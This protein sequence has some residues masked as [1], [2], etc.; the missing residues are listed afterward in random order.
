MLVDFSSTPFVR[1]PRVSTL[2]RCLALLLSAQFIAPLY[3]AGLELPKTL[4]KDNRSTTKLLVPSLQATTGK[5]GKALADEFINTH[6][7]E[8]SLSPDISPLELYSTRESLLGTHYRYRQMLNGIPVQGAEVVVSVR[9]KNDQVY[10]A[11]NNSYPIVHLPPQGKNLLGKEQALDTAW[12]HLQVHGRLFKKPEAQLVYLPGGENFRLVYQTDIACEAPLGNWRHLIDA[13]SGE[14]VSVKDRIIYKNSRKPITDDLAYKGAIHSRSDATAQLPQKA[15][16]K[17]KSSPIGKTTVN[18]T[19]L[20][21]DPDPRTHLANDALLDT[22]PASEFSAA[23][24]TRTLR[25]ISEDDGIYSLD[26]PWVKVVDFDPPTAAPSTTTDGNWTALRGNNAFNDAMTY[27]HVDQNQRYLQSLGF[28]GAKGVQQKQISVDTHGANGG[29]NSFFI[30]DTNSLNFGHGGVDDNEDA[31]VILHEYGHAL[32][33]D[34]IPSW[35]GGDTG[36]IGEGFG[37]YWGASYKYTTLN[38]PTYHP[39]WAFPWDGHGSD[40]WPGRRLDYTSLTYDP[41]VTYRDHMFING[42]EQYSDQLWGTPLFQAFLTLIAQ[43][44]PRAEIDQIVIESF[45]GMG[46][47]PTMRD[48]ATSTVNA[49]ALLFPLGPHAEVFH[50]KFFDQNILTL[51]PGSFIATPNGSDQIDLAWKTSFSAS[52]TLIA[53]NTQEVFGSPSG[54]PDPG[55]LLTGG[56]LILYRG[57]SS[58]TSHLALPPGNYYYKAWSR[59]SDGSYSSG[60]S[61]SA[62]LGLQLGDILLEEDFEEGGAQPASWT[63]QTVNG[64]ASWT[65]QNGGHDGNPAAAH[66]GSSNALL[67]AESSD[68]NR[69]KL[70]T[71]VI[72]LGNL[73]GSVELEFWHC[74]VGWDADQDELRVY[75]KTSAGG[76][77]TLLETYTA[78]V[79]SW[80]R[81]MIALPNPS[82]TY[83]LAF[84]GNAK[85]AYGVCLD[86]VQVQESYA[87]PAFIVTNNQTT[88]DES[89][90]SSAGTIT[91]TRTGASPSAQSVTLS[92]DDHSELTLP[93]SAIIP[94]GLSSVRVNFDA[95]DDEIDDGPQTVTITA[96]APGFLPG[97]HILQV[98]DDEESFLDW[99]TDNGLTGPMA[100]AE[101][102]PFGD[103]I[104]NIDKYAF[105][106]NGQAFDTTKLTPGSGLAGLPVLYN[107]N[108]GIPHFEFVRRTNGLI[109]YTLESS[110]NS[111]RLWSPV[112]VT[113]SDISSIDR[114]WER[115]SVGITNSP[116]VEKLFY[117]LSITLPA[118]P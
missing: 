66:G 89:D 5:T 90:G 11:F 23:Y 96:S 74:M 16:T 35:G 53:W 97:T 81:R 17:S 80:T 71:P 68:D 54:T 61:N 98:D 92:S 44:V 7:A 24:V 110:Q 20:V 36:A 100:Q 94:A 31:N 37:D 27:F 8:F 91:I 48:L 101:A 43:G 93:V 4:H 87:Q 77:W 39:E 114:H 82:A 56:G 6:R 86:D 14:I 34:I 112:T 69:T 25:D 22:S 12:N 79:G 105:N 41:N 65:Y 85:Y 42:I 19:A 26:G 15:K 64:S 46:G 55:A 88:I 50:Q 103:G 62:S 3:G 113:P 115:V 59:L 116:L 13:H 21:F 111:L 58:T 47:N 32:T 83:S 73:A 52:E 84:E 102:Q 67:F 51:D 72:D 75:Y 104:T 28:F 109:T 76:A 9:H 45:F 107:D 1:T 10:Q 57:S 2:R 99:A 40:T 30:P 78:S 118:A 106:M 29:D 63:Q 33:F 38:G 117:R 60:V 18:G 108:S 70:V 49:A 95:I